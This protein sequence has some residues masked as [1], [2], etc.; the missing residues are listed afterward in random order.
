MN[1]I[2]K[3]ITVF[4]LIQSHGFSQKPV[5]TLKGRV[6]DRDGL[7]GLPGANIVLVGTEPLLGTST[8]ADG[9]YRIEKV[10]VGRY[11]LR[12]TFLGYESST[13]EGILITSGKEAILDIYLKESVISLKSIEI[14]AKGNN[15]GALNS[16]SALNARGIDMKEANRYAGGVDDPSRLVS[17]FAGVSTGL[18]NNGIVIRGNS[19]KSLLWRLEEVEISNPNHF[20]N[21]QTFGGGGLTALSSQVMANSDFYTA[22]FPAEYGNALSGVFDIRMRTGNQDK[23][24]YTFQVGSNGIDFACEGPFIKERNSTYLLNYRYSSLALINDLLPPEAGKISY[25]DLSFKV[26]LPTKKTG[27]FSIW[28]LSA[29]DKQK[30]TAEN[31]SNKWKDDNSRKN[32]ESKLIMG[33]AGVSHRIQIKK[34]A[35][36]SSVIAISGNLTESEESLLTRQGKINP[37]VDLSSLSGQVTFR[38]LLNYKFSPMHTNRTGFSYSRIFYNL[39]INTADKEGH[40]MITRISGK[41]N[42]SLISAFTQSK[43]DISDKWVLN[44]GINIQFFA[45]N[46][47]FSPEPRASLQW[48][49]SPVQC[50]SISYGLHSRLE[51]LNLYRIRFEYPSGSSYPNTKLEFPKSHHIVLAWKYRLSPQISLKVEPYYQYLFNIPVVP[52]SPLSMIN[53]EDAWSF[54]DSLVNE[55]TG[56]NIGIDFTLERNLERGYYFLICASLFDSRYKGGDGIIRSTRYN[57][58]Y[59]VNLLTGREWKP[60]KSKKNLMSANIRL[61]LMGGNKIETPDFTASQAAEMI[62]YDDD[63][64]FE[65]SFPDSQILSFSLSYR[66]N[67]TNHSSV[68]TFQIINALSQLEYEGY[69]YDAFTNTIVEEKDPFV[70]PSISYKVEF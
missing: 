2:L 55:G 15:S 66:K 63:Q 54:D 60:G 1:I 26:S 24:E 45:L 39:D 48:N 4:L 13:I 47:N 8:N 27:V 64:I 28:S 34:Q 30:L 65:K 31:D 19:P 58:Q 41:D 36:I 9:Y 37:L 68:W 44:T 53:Q 56:T 5:Q 42:T 3:I 16:M 49:S 50:W 40:P 57:K 12:C 25:Q 21:L 43:L 70:I 17:S 46:Q 6:Y 32:Y 14:K 61:C 62:I 7:F 20:A 35:N 33:A 23:R 38:S 29:T 22:A 52:G 59:I 69:R 11:T 67:K 18:S 51:M 10:P